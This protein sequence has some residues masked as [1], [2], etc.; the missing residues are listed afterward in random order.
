[1]KILF[2]QKKPGRVR[3]D[4]VPVEMD[5]EGKPATVGQ[6]IEAAVRRVVASFNRR[7]MSAPGEPDSD[8]AR[9][10]IGSE[11]MADLVETGRV[12][13]GIVYNGRQVDPGEAVAN[14]LQCYDDGLFRI[15]LNGA[16]LEGKDTVIDLNEDD[17]LTVVRL[18]LL[19]GRLW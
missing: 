10:F 9:A 7:A 6:L 4:I 5:I 11:C 13:F 15:F 8:N 18:T 14:A 19:A 12:A 16:P 1:M 17:I 2:E 3:Q